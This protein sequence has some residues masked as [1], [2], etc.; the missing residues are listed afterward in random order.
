MSVTQ[1]ERETYETLVGT[2]PQYADFSPAEQYLPIFLEIVGDRRGT[3][4]DA[5]CCTGKGGVFLASHGFDVTLCDLTDAGLT[6]E[7]MALPF[8]RMSLWHDLRL[9]ARGK[10]HPSRSSFD[11]VVCCDVLEHIPTHFTMLVIDQ[12]LRVTRHGLFL[13]ISLVPDAFGSWVGT[14]LHQ[15][16]QPYLWWRE[17]IGELGRVVEARDLIGSAVFYVR[18]T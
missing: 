18:P 10:G 13:S 2:V 9:T 11:Y 17:G 1:H 4:L 15:T 7:A 8:V 6:S 14:V 3:V 16:V 5:G 12:L